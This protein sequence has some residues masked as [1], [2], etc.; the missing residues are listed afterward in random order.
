MSRASSKFFSVSYIKIATIATALCILFTLINQGKHNLDSTGNSATEGTGLGSDETSKVSGASKSSVVNKAAH[1]QEDGSAEELA[2][3]SRNN[4]NRDLGSENG[5]MVS[6]KSTVSQKN[7]EVIVPAEYGHELPEHQVFYGEYDKRRMH[8]PHITGV[9]VTYRR[10]SMDMELYT[11]I[12]NN[13]TLFD[14][15]EAELPKLGF[16]SDLD[17]IVYTDGGD[18]G[19]HRYYEGYFHGLPSPALHRGSAHPRYGRKLLDKKAAPT[20]FRA[21]LTAFRQVNP[22]LGELMK[23]LSREMQRRGYDML[24]KLF[25]RNELMFSDLAVQVHFGD[26]QKPIWHNDAINSILHM[27]ITMH[28]KRSLHTLL[29]K[30][31]PDE[32]HTIFVANGRNPETGQQRRDYNNIDMKRGFVNPQAP[33]DVYISS[34]TGFIHGVTYPTSSYGERTIAVQCRLLMTK[35]EFWQMFDIDQDEWFRIIAEHVTPLLSHAD[36]QLPSFEKTRQVHAELTRWG[37]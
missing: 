28:G 21:F 8:G 35:K 29:H 15:S 12:F 13:S 10:A 20:R 3:K 1:P 17:D 7:V 5:K 36:L 37:G 30:E 4:N 32:E 16:L 31:R 19:P 34:P 9:P 26:E 22:W 14:V 18:G 2:T 23:T 33:A 11:W 6:Q 24:A 25:T 27:A